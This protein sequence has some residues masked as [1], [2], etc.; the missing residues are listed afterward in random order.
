MVGII[1][2]VMIPEWERA[3]EVAATRTPKKAPQRLNK[4]T[5][6]VPVDAPTARSILTL[7]IYKFLGVHWTIYHLTVIIVFD[8]VTESYEYSTN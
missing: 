7:R 2:P 6:F 4:R 8:L 1:T 5:G 3:A